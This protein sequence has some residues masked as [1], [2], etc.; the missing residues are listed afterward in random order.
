MPRSTRSEEWMEGEKEREN[1]TGK[2]SWA[3]K[4]GQFYFRESV[5]FVM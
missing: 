5:C 4:M 1:G 2:H 3:A